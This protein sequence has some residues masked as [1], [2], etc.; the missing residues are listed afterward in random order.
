MKH[1]KKL[2]ALAI[3]LAAVLALSVTAWADPSVV[4]AN[5]GTIESSVTFTD[6]FTISSGDD[7]SNLP[8]ATFNYA[9]APGTGSAATASAPLIK[10]GVT[11]ATI[12]NAAHTATASGTTT[13]SATVTADFSSCSFTEAGIYRYAVTETLGTSNVSADIAIDVNN[14]NLG[15]YVLDVYVK[16]SGSSFVPYAYIMTKSGTIT[17]YTN[18]TNP[19]TV[20]YSDK[21]ATIT[22]EYTTY[23]LTV[24]KTIVGDLA[25]NSFVFTINLS[26]L[27]TDVVFTQDSATNTGNT[28]YTLTATLANGASTEIKGLP[29]TAAYQIQ[30]AVNQLEGYTVTVS[31]SNT[32]AGTYAW[33]GGTDSSDATAFGNSSTTTLGKADTTVG[34]TNTLNS[35]SPTG[36]VFRVAPYVAMLCVGIPLFVVM[37][38]RRKQTAR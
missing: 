4:N 3:A 33:I 5:T 23:N 8:A 15:T 31:D 18:S 30:E 26:G 37:T 21:V 19:Q 13:D 35:L 28:S 25:A 10:A 24:S 9:I 1:I 14:S 29:S 2:A 34:F 7:A 17:S 11:G 22:N 32:S 20:E 27:P 12:T 16:K 36:L 6:T 38:R